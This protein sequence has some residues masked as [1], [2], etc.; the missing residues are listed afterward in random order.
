MKIVSY[1]I[2]RGFDSKKVT[3]LK[4]IIKYLN[5]LDS[6][7]ICLQEVLYNQFLKIKSEL[8][9]DGVFA[10]NVNNKTMKYGI[11]TLSK[12][13]I[14]SNHHVLL[15]SKK[16]QRGLLSINV[17][18]GDIDN[19][20]IINTHLGL[21]REERNIQIEE[22]LNFK[23]RLVGSSLI[24]GDF[25]EK[26]IYISNYYDSAV[27]LKKDYIPTLPKYNARID[28]IFVENIYNPKEYIVDKITLSDHYPII[29]V[30]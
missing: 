29:C 6:D 4:K 17:N 8:G 9:I 14:K 25:N 7:I 27:Y 21:D 23:N 20:N 30:F 19:I 10:A 24:C 11:C 2:H 5:K 3:S 15:T 22:I 13:K 18:T 12:Y 1:N 16:E 26:N 28:Y